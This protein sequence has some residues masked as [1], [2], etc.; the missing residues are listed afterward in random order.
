VAEIDLRSDTVTRPTPE[1]RRAMAEAEVGDDVYGED[2]TINRLQE[3]AAEKV[4]HESALFVPSGTMGNQACIMAHTQRG[5]E[6]LLEE[7]SHIF[8]Y[9]AGGAA[10]LS[11]CQTRTLPGQGGRLSPSQVREAVRG[12]NMHFPRTGLLCLENTHNRAGGTV[13]SP[14]LTQ[15]LVEVAHEAGVKVH[16]DGARVFNASCAQDIDVK[17]LTA[18][19][20]SVQ[21]CLSKGL[22]APVGSVIAG[23]AAFID[24]CLRAR[25][26]LGGGMRQAGILAAAGIIALQEMTGR[27]QEDH[28]T[29]ARLAESVAEME[30]FHLDPDDVYTNIVAFDVDPAWFTAPQF[31]RQLRRHEVLANSI[32]TQRIRMV[33]HYQVDSEAICDAVDAMHRATCELK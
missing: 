15:Q 5:Q 27:L 17:Q 31:L 10:L 16:L 33:T 8:L 19:V 21:F 14:Q 32:H 23:S 4:G 22:A 20:D 7:Q 2:P 11:G 6:I 25:K 28:E 29:A 3:L 24:E 13:L 1:M 12:D 26:V 30:P 18:G 9:E